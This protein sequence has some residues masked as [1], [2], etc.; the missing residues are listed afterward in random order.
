MHV[1]LLLQ[2]TGVRV[3]HCIQGLS[4]S[5]VCDA[6]AYGSI[7]TWSVSC[8]SGIRIVIHP[9]ILSGYLGTFL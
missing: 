9:Y 3:V 4:G 8:T 1:N 7:P 6:D 5:D 2:A